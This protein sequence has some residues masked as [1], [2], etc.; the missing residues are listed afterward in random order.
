MMPAILV[1]LSGVAA[2]VYQI[3]WVKQLALIVGVDVYAVTT[4]VSAFFAGLALGGGLFGRR[5]DRSARPLRLFAALEAGT[6]LLGFTATLVLAHAA[7]AFVSLEAKASPVAWA[8]LFVT[9]GLPALLMGGTLP[10]L[11]R[12]VAPAE[13]AVG[14]ASGNL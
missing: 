1:F 9:I 6:G 13:E 4:A 3:L 14:R 2:L 12:A 11:V 8:L 10:A 7:P 5:A